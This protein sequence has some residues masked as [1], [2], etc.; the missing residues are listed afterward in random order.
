MNDHVPFT[1]AL[2][3]PPYLLGRA[4]GMILGSSV[5]LVSFLAGGE[6]D[7]IMAKFFEKKSRG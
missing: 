2:L 4:L 6:Y 7:S 5:G 1:R 3:K